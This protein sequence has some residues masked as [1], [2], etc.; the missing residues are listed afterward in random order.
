MTFLD[1][2]QVDNNHQKT[3]GSTADAGVD[4]GRSSPSSYPERRERRKRE[5]FS[6]N[7]GV[8]Y[9][10]ARYFNAPSLPSF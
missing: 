3:Y 5:S 1:Q 10:A 6:D 8:S 7:I 4:D 2:L 9:A